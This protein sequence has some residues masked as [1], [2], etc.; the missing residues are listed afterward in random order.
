[1]GGMRRG[2]S[3]VLL[4]TAALSSAA[5]AIANRVSGISQAKELQ[6]TGE[7]AEATILE[8]WDTGW[9]VNEDP[10]VGFTLEV[11]RAGMPA[12]QAKTKLIVSRVQV[13][14]FRPG[15]VVPVLVDPKDPSKVS[16]DVY[17]FSDKQTKKYK[18]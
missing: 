1:M 15:A 5:C 18:I 7:A 11:R 2:L 8:I 3:A 4:L 6:E 16:L 17:D 10:V 12:Y 9:T 14:A 13:A